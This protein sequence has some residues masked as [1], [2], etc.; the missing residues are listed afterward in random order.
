MTQLPDKTSINRGSVSGFDT[1]HAQN[2][3]KP[4]HFAIFYFETSEIIGS[5]RAIDTLH[6]QDPTQITN[7]FCNYKRID[8]HMTF[9]NRHMKYK[10]RGP[11]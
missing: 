11:N 8:S 7:S 9:S 10:I 3:G 2:P 1:L 5:V 4:I 6:A